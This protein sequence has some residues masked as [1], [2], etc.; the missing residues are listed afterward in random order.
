MF[1]PG[2]LGGVAVFAAGVRV[3]RR[4]RGWAGGDEV[5]QVDRAVGADP[6]VRQVQAG[7]VGGPPPP[8]AAT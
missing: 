1:V 2:Q 4:E 7:V 5:K 3:G 8:A 6:Q